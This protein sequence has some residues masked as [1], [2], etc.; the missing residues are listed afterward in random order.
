MA[1]RCDPDSDHTYRVTP[2]CGFT[3]GFTNDT[4]WCEASMG[5]NGNPEHSWPTKIKMK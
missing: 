1:T 5:N 3:N 2:T 4:Q